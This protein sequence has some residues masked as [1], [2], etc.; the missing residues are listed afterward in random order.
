MNVRFRV[1]LASILCALGLM[2]SVGASAQTAAPSQNNQAFDSTAE[3]RAV[4][5]RFSE[6]FEGVD[7]TG[8]RLTPYGIYEVLVGGD[9][10]YTDEKVTWVMEGPLIDAA[11]RRDVSRERLQQL[12][13]IPFAE[14]PLELA[15]KQVRGKGTR[16]MAIFEDPNCG[17][18]KQLHQVL[19]DEDDV[20]IYSFLFPILSPDSAIKS[21]DIWCAKDRAGAWNDWI[22]DGKV[23]ATAECDT[24]VD[25]V[26]ALGKKLLVRGTPAIFFEDGSRLNG[27][28]PIEVIRRHLNP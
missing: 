10:V 18:C 6:R 12:S 11:T 26:L 7:V 1:G 9:L 16:K 4:A 28:M 13:A 24:P 19:K 23:P 22:I 2:A 5:Q 27:A 3:D 21:R 17:Y 8:A 15:V 25:D 14:L 20:T